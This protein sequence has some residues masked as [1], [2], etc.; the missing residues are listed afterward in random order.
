MILVQTKAFIRDSKKLKM[1][2]KH[3]T[4]PEI[5][6]RNYKTVQNFANVSQLV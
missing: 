6:W 2:D 1:S 5:P 3:F 4:K